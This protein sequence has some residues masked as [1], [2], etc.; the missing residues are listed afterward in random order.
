VTR[1]NPT[2][3][4]STLDKAAAAA[5][6]PP[7]TGAQRRRHRQGAEVVWSPISVARRPGHVR[8]GPEKPVQQASLAPTGRV[9]TT[10]ATPSVQVSRSAPDGQMFVAKFRESN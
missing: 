10:A 5:G 2:N 8:R 6:G 4:D 9:V 7:E 1:A 3:T